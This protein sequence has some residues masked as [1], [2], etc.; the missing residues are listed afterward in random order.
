MAVHDGRGREE[1][2]DHLLRPGMSNK[3]SDPTKQRRTLGVKSFGAEK[4]ATSRPKRAL[5]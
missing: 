4:L 2:A 3:V 5:V 1:Y